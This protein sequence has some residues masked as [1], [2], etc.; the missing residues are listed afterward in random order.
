MPRTD[1]SIIKRISI[2]KT[3]RFPQLTSANDYQ[4][5]RG[6]NKSKHITKHVSVECE[7]LANLARLSTRLNPNYFSRFDIKALH[8]LSV[9]TRQRSNVVRKYLARREQVCCRRP[10]PIHQNFFYLCLY[11]LNGEKRHQLGLELLIE[12]ALSPGV[13]R[14]LP[15]IMNLIVSSLIT[16]IIS[17][18]WTSG[19]NVQMSKWFYVI[20]DISV[21]FETRGV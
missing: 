12:V 9:F 13:V 15:Q 20:E 14:V 7:I 2:L 16:S 19:L 18:W 6:E 1:L 3:Q 11:S 5:Q 4:Y 8:I 17:T 21:F 10:F